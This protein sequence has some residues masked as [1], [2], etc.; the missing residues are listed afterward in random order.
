MTL[1][2]TL[3][4]THRGRTK[5]EEEH[6]TTGA[7]F[8]WVD[9]FAVTLVLKTCYTGWGRGV[10]SELLHVSGLV[11]A[12]AIACNWYE[13][14]ARWVAQWVAF[15]PAKL[16]FVLFLVLLFMLLLL[17]QIAIRLMG[18]LIQW[19]RVHWAV[20]SLGLIVGGLRGIWLVGLCVLIFIATGLP[21]LVESVNERSLVGPSL[22]RLSMQYLQEAADWLPHERRQELI[23]N[24]KFQLPTLPS[25]RDNF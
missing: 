25:K 22:V 19:E 21:P 23:P 12:S 8:N 7:T 16:N 11:L 5:N 13:P 20:Q 6:A 9:L 2:E 24:A 10:L 3:C 18:K 4:Y 1:K 14:V 15:D 17:F